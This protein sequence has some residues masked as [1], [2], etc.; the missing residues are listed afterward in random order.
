[1]YVVNSRLADTLIIQTAA[2]SPAKI[3]YRRL[4]EIN[5]RFYGLFLLRALTCGPKGVPN[6]GS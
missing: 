5:S 1:M 4:I 2:T 3:N 6:N